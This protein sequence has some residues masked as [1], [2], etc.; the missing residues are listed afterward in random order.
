MSDPM[1]RRLE[2]SELLRVMD[3]AE[4]IR[5]RRERMTQGAF[6]RDATV[7]EIQAMYEDLGD[8]VERDVIERALDQYQAER[9][10]FTPPRWGPATVLAWIYVRRSMVLRRV[11]APAVVAGAMVWGAMAFSAFGSQRALARDTQSLRSA[12]TILQA[13]YAEDSRTLREYL[14]SQAV[15]ALSEPE[16][17][18]VARRTRAVEERLASVTVTLS[19]VSGLALSSDPMTR[20][21]L[22]L[23]R[24][25][26]DIAQSQLTAAK[27]D[28]AAVGDI[29]GTQER[30]AA[31]TAEVSTLQVSI[32]EAAE[33]PGVVE[34]ATDVLALARRQAALRD[35]A[36]LEG[37]VAR[38]R[39][40]L[41]TLEEEYRIQIVGGVW[42]YRDDDPS[43][44][45]Y[46]LRVQAVAADG[47]VV[48]RS[49]RNEENG[50]VEVVGEW[51]ERVPK[52][53]YDRV[54]ADK[55]DNGIIDDDAFG[56]KR[57]GWVTMERRY[58]DVGQIT[59]W[60]DA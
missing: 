9:Y 45:N 1:P 16:A 50:R 23:Q 26:V 4:V 31:L 56:S 11:V 13:A 14:G 10:A 6:D 18:E 25:R 34:E 43:V 44:R 3:A 28:L 12:I 40:T 8:L 57:R 42:R 52:E 21:A 20:P 35:V 60:P 17:A 22:D 27:A 2:P 29:L 33:E 19:D 46:Y 5:A 58:P 51:G 37:S 38:L 39:R 53:V 32:R 24:D 48:P 7:R 49:V 55:Q 36:S 41:A 54:G 15:A 30:L 59:S 47:S